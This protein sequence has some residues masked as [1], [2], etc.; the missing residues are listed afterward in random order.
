LLELFR[1]STPKSGA[2]E[3]V[4]AL[5]RR[6][7]PIAVATSSDRK[8][9]EAKT[10]HHNW[11]RF[12]TVVCA[13]DAEVARHK[14]APDVFL[15]AAR[16]LGVPPNRCLVFEDSIAGVEAARRAKVARIVAIV[17]PLLDKSQVSAASV[18]VESYLELGDF[19][20]I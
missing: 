18:I 9:L 2:V 17:D 11:F 16:Q 15:A 13:S 5:R 10:G 14:P 20:L 12:D 1:S 4:A 8:F 6:G 3:L 7:L 19:S